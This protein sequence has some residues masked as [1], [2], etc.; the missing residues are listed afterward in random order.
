M[1]QYQSRLNEVEEKK[2]IK[3]AMIFG[4]LTLLVIILGIFFGIPLFSKFINLFNKSSTAQNSPTSVPSVVAPTLSVLPKYTNQQ[5]IS[6][7]G[8][9]LANSTI[10][11]FFNDS[12]DETTTDENGNFEIK[13]GLVKG[14]NT[15]YAKTIDKSKNESESS[16]SYV[17][18]F[19]TQTPNLTVN[20]PQNNQSF[21]GS[22]QQKLTVQ[23]STDVGNTVT[24]NDHMAILDSSGKFSFPYD[25]QNGDNQ[26]K[27]ISM[28]QAGNKKEI[29]IKVTFNP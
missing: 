21:Y 2:S 25:L 4:G 17:V 19:T 7:K 12:S 10:K 1:R 16:N 9:A 27:I 8:S 26:I 28:D 15:I 3:S 13:I 18:N 23:G 6:V 11:I 24:I 22:T 14:V 20:V 5:N 29:D